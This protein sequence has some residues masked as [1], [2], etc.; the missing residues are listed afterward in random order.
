MGQKGQ[1]TF[2]IMVQLESKTL[3][4]KIEIL[5]V[6]CI[7][8]LK[9][10]GELKWFL[11]PIRCSPL[12]LTGPVPALSRIVTGALSS[13][14]PRLTWGEGNI[15]QRDLKPR[16]LLRHLICRIEAQQCTV[17]WVDSWCAGWRWALRWSSPGGSWPSPPPR[18]SPPWRL[19]P[20]K[21]AGISWI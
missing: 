15:K 16:P 10:L 21:S 5:A 2:C 8:G 13:N 4:A 7:S 18:C 11:L 20:D 9:V 17:P 1:I 3:D 14:S 12:T 19:L 6:W